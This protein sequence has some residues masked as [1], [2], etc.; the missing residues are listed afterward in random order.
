MAHIG[1]P[2]VGDYTY[3]SDKLTYRMFLHAASLTLPL[4]ELRAAPLRMESPLC[5]AGWSNAFEPSE[6]LRLPEGDPEARR[7]VEGIL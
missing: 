5:P 7:L 4:A 6:A 1:H 2:I 3:A